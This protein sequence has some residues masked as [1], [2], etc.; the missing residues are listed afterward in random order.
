M[1]SQESKTSRA[2]EESQGSRGCT[3]HSA[4]AGEDFL[5]RTLHFWQAR[6]ARPLSR[7]DALQI[8]RNASGFFQVLNEWALAERHDRD[9]RKQSS[10]TVPTKD[11][12]A[13]RS[14][15][16]PGWM[17]RAPHPCGESSRHKNEQD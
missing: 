6:S 1:V 16:Q 9:P 3:A 11:L 15:L 8:V 17:S 12:E 4:N 13:V 14:E 5:N 10:A 2:P 7:E